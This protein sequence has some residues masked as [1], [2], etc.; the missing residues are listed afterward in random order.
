MKEKLNCPN[1]GAPITADKCEYCGTLFYDFANIEVGKPSYLRMKIGD[2]L[3][4]F[5]GV[6]INTEIESNNPNV[7]YYADNN[8]YYVETLPEWNVTISFRVVADDR[9]VLMEKRNEKWKE[10][11][12]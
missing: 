7:I 11:N 10:Q 6:P 9:G 2:T 8:P 12:K 3:N 5:R 1:C 4:I